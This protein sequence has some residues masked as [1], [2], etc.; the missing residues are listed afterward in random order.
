M[1]IVLTLDKSILVLEAIVRRPEG[2]GTR[3]L[4]QELGIN[5]ATAHN[6]ATTFAARGYVRQDEVTRLFHPGLRLMLLSRL[7]KHLRDLATTAR[8]VV[9]AL[10]D[11]LDEAVMLV[12][13]DNGR[14]ITIEYAANKQPLRVV[15]ESEDMSAVAHCTASGKL[16]LAHFDETLLQS[17]LEQFKLVR[18]TANT[19][20]DPEAFRAQLKQL[21]AQEFCYCRDEM[22]E[23]ISALSVPIRDPWGAIFGALGA[24]APTVRLQTVEQIDISLNG[25]RRAAAEI[26]RIWANAQQ[27]TASDVPPGNRRGRPRKYP[28]PVASA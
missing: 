6:I 26:E 28:K 20:T 1:P 11:E 21:R 17:H 13:N 16:I 10:A 18:H 22:C 14:L 8:R 4:A 23:G 9:H 2:I 15:Q 7:P 24:S 12:S 5:V 3:A 25:L 27:F 19:V